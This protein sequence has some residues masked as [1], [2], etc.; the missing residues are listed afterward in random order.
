[1]SLALLLAQKTKIENI[2]IIAGK[3][4]GIVKGSHSSSKS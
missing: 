1:V 3:K 2:K 4:I